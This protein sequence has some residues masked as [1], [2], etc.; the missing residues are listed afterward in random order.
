[1]PTLDY[2]AAVQ[3][4]LDDEVDVFLADAPIITLTAMRYP[5]AGLAVLNKPLTVEPIGIAVS[6]DDPLLLNLVENYLEALDGTGGLKN[7]QTKW[8]ENAGWLTQLP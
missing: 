8:F 3:L 5:N 2:D 4:L 1:V 6:P 7:L